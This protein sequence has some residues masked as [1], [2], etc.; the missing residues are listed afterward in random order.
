MARGAGRRARGSGLW[1]LA[2]LALSFRR[3]A[4][5]SADA[6]SALR[7]VRA[8]GAPPAAGGRGLHAMVLLA[9]ETGERPA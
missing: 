4:D 7:P 2:E 6:A 9:A 3:D 8:E 1:R 5:L